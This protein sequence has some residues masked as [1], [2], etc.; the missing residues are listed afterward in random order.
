MYRTSFKDRINPPCAQFPSNPVTADPF[1][2]TKYTTQKKCASGLWSKPFV[3]NYVFLDN[4]EPSNVPFTTAGMCTQNTTCTSNR[5]YTYLNTLDEKSPYFRK[6]ADG[7]YTSTTADARLV[8]SRHSHNQQ[9]N[10]PPLQ[11]VYNMFNDNVSGNPRLKDCGRN[12]T[13]YASIN[14]GQI[15]YY[16]GDDLA[17]PFPSPVYGMR[18]KS[19]GMMY[20]NPMDNI[21]PTFTKAYST[22][23]LEDGLSFINDTTKFRDDII[24]RQ[25]RIHNSQKYELVYGKNIA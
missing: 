3:P 6:T 10:E 2:N 4:I 24:S 1:N 16:I 12:Y 15:R 23:I 18:S 25:Q 14:Y 8:D 9:L 11:V 5:N 22:E 20:K 19:T 13:D 21:V 17:E 7:M